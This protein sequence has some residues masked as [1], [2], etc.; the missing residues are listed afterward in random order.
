M[1]DQL[2]WICLKLRGSGWSPSDGL[3]TWLTID[4]LNQAFFVHQH[5]GSGVLMSFGVKSWWFHTIFNSFSVSFWST[6]VILGARYRTGLLNPW[7][8]VGNSSWRACASQPPLVERLLSCRWTELF[9]CFQFQESRRWG[10]RK[11]VQCAIKLRG[12][13]QEV[14][15]P[16]GL[17]DPQCPKSKWIH[18]EAT[19]HVFGG[20]PK[21]KGFSKI[22]EASGPFNPNSPGVSDGVIAGTASRRESSRLEWKASDTGHLVTSCDKQWTKKT[23]TFFHLF[24]KLE[25][26]SHSKPQHAKI[27][28]FCWRSLFRSI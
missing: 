11:K 2:I 15:A 17:K 3:W 16:Y 19:W 28:E 27:Q 22:L 23:L 26:G 4:G 10:V 21:A 8:F 1:L 24:S 18:I 14:S 20:T 5:P 12:E 9:S 13:C 6:I 25:V 7:V